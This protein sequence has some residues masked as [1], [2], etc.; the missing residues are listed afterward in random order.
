MCTISFKL[1]HVMVTSSLSSRCHAFIIFVIN[2]IILEE[3]SLKMEIEGC[4]GWC[5]GKVIQNIWFTF[6]RMLETRYMLWENYIYD[7]LNL[8]LRNVIS[9]LWPAH[10][11][12]IRL[13]TSWK[14]GTYLRKS[15]CMV[16]KLID[17]GATL[18]QFEF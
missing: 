15:V 6:Q 14:L 2:G 4:T 9:Y 7:F 1:Q 5:C 12:S 17:P 16:I 10:C 13:G 11:F 8:Q 3:E 18:P